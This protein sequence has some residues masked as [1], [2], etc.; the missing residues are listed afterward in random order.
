[1]INSDA[2]V[3]L[4][5][6]LKILYDGIGTQKEKKT[7]LFPNL[8]NTLDPPSPSLLQ[9]IWWGKRYSYPPVDINVCICIYFIFGSLKNL[10][11]YKL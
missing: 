3:T 10:K 4:L 11:Q 6:Y 7:A 1:M 8:E 9:Q 5:V 2:I